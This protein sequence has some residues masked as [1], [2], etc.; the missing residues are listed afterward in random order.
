MKEI[1]FPILA[2]ALVL[3]S[4]QSTTV[5]EVLMVSTNAEEVKKIIDQKNDQLEILYKTRQIDSVATYFADDVIQMPPNSPAIKG[6]EM[7]KERWMEATG[8]AEWDFQFEA[9]EVRRTG[10]M[11]VELGKYT[12]NLTPTENSPIPPIEDSGHYIVLWEF[13]DGD[14]KIVW[15]APVSENPLPMPE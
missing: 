1:I 5:S 11:A 15:D 12:L 14:W 7:Y 4:C 6:I 10:D 8:M 9:Q 13:I 3:S 2:V